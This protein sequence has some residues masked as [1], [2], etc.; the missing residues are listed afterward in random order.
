MRSPARRRTSTWSTTLLAGCGAVEPVPRLARRRRAARA[1][2]CSRALV[3]GGEDPATGSAAGPLCAY[4]RARGRGERVE[5]TQG[6]EI[7]RPSRLL[8]EM[9]GD[10]VRVSGGVVPVIEGTVSL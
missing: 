5:I 4:L 1:R 7:G 8:A 3:E 2:G 6:V 9:D 10:R